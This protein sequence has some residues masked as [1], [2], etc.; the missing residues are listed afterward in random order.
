MLEKPS[1]TFLYRI[2]G[3]FFLQEIDPGIFDLILLYILRIV[4]VYFKFLFCWRRV[5]FSSSC[6]PELAHWSLWYGL[7][8]HI[9]PLNVQNSE[10]VGKRKIAT[11]S[12]TL[13]ISWQPKNEK[14]WSEW[15]DSFSR[16]NHIYNMVVVLLKPRTSIFT[17]FR[18]K[19]NTVLCRWFKTIKNYIIKEMGSLVGRNGLINRI[20]TKTANVSCSFYFI[21]IIFFNPKKERIYYMNTVIIILK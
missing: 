7:V 12:F 15:S 10:T 20:I 3:F 2:L 16:N 21:I 18:K 4:L 9:S 1:L 17:V 13:T 8:T 5:N 19:K 14:I 11:C 6:V